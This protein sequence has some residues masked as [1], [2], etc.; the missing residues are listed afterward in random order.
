MSR[1]P[2]KSTVASL[3][4]SRDEDRQRKRR[5]AN[6]RMPEPTDPLGANATMIRITSYF[7]PSAYARLFSSL[8]L[9]VL[10]V[11]SGADDLG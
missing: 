5:D 2:S 4:P 10:V 9:S 8:F 11:A 3:V 1:K 6:L 7:F